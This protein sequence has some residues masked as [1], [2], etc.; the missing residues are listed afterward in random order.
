M[1]YYLVISVKDADMTLSDLWGKPI[2]NR[3]VNF[4][5]ETQLDDFVEKKV[6]AG[7]TCFTFTYHTTSRITQTVGTFTEILNRN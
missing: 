7:F 6:N 5:D 2:L 1:N 3:D 4:L